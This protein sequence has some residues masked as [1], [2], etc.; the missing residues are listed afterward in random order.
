MT[1]IFTEAHGGSINENQRKELLKQARKKHNVKSRIYRF[2]NKI[3][4]FHLL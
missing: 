4:I 1:D 2:Y 3:F